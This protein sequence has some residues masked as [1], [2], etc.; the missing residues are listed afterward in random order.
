MTAEL[1]GETYDLPVVTELRHGLFPVTTVDLS[2]LPPMD[3][4]D[5][6]SLTY[7]YCLDAG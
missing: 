1:R 3:S 5:S 7:T 4:G 6:V 2:V